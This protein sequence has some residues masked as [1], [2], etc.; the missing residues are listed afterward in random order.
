MERLVF[1]EAPDRTELTGVL[2]GDGQGPV[3]VLSHGSAMRFCQRSYVNI[4]RELADRG[5]SLLSGETRGHDIAA[6]H[7]RGDDFVGGGGAFERF[8]ESVRD[9]DAWLRYA[10]DAGAEPVVAMGHSMGGT[11]T[12][13]ALSAG[14]VADALV[15]LSPAVSWPVN[16]ERVAIARD[17]IDHGRGDDLM[18]PRWDAPPWNLISAKTLA[19][20]FDLIEGVFA[21]AG[22][23]WS[24][25]DI[26]TLVLFG[27]GEEDVDTDLDALTSARASAQRLDCRVI[28]DAD[29]EFRGAEA[30]VADVVAEWL[31]D[32]LTPVPTSEPQPA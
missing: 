12:V 18:P 13:L 23:P 3:A 24:R 14:A 25:I 17:L 21:S 7:R 31:S 4:G 32:V 26:P 5:V 2:I 6:L 30:R 20:R 27:A 1:T 10:H 29:H 11:K 8:D 9:C 15:L 22:G 19:Q 16:A 28:D